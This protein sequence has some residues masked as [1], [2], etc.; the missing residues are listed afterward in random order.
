MESWNTQLEELLGVPREEAV[1]RKLE[2]VLPADL[3]AE[4]AAR[5]SDERVSSIYKF[6]LQ[7]REGRRL[8]VN[9]SIA[10]LVGKI[11]ERDR[12]ADPVR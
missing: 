10:P 11:G 2:E 4:I 3:A 1:G 9:V 7:N 6:H 8:V 12:A 5:A